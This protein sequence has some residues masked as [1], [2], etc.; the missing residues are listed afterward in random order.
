[1]VWHTIL[2]KRSQLNFN[3]IFINRN[4]ITHFPCIFF[5]IRHTRGASIE[6]KKRKL[7]KNATGT[8]AF[9]SFYQKDRPSASQLKKCLTS[10]FVIPIKFI[11]SDIPSL[12]IYFSIQQLYFAL[13]ATHL[14]K[15]QFVDFSISNSTL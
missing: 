15:L 5:S 3:F 4:F 11:I 14:K 9:V 12:R 6:I 13:N 8:E 10:K 7:N 1:M 2:Q